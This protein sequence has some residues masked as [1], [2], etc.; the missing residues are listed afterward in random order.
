MTEHINIGLL[1]LSSYFTVFLWQSCDKIICFYI[2]HLVCMSGYKLGK[3]HLGKGPISKKHES[4]VFDHR[5]EGG[6]LPKP[7]PYSDQFLLC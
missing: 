5:G 7:N 3:Y 1:S 2:S 4:M 6:G